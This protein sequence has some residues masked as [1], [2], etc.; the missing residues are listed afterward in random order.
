MYLPR[1]PREVLVAARSVAGGVFALG[2]GMATMMV[3]ACDPEAKETEDEVE[4]PRR[5]ECPAW[6]CTEKIVIQAEDMDE[7]AD[8]YG[9]DET[10]GWLKNQSLWGM[11][12]YPTPPFGLVAAGVLGQC[13]PTQSVDCEYI[14]YLEFFDGEQEECPCEVGVFGELAPYECCYNEGEEE[15]FADVVDEEFNYS[16]AEEIQIFIDCEGIDVGSRVDCF[17]DDNPLNPYYNELENGILSEIVI[18]CATEETLSNVTGAEYL[19][20]VDPAWSFVTVHVGSDEDTVPLAGMGATG[21]GT[22]EFLMGI[23]D[24]TDTLELEDD[25]SNWQFWFDTTIYTSGT[26]SAFTVPADYDIM[27]AGQVETD[28]YNVTFEPTEHASGA[29]NASTG[30]W[31]VDFSGE[32]TGGWAEIHLEG[33][34]NGFSP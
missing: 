1:T 24:A 6:I 25:Y 29:F 33:D 12:G 5:I 16:T 2:L 23:V 13:D 3:A 8:C 19:L 32:F 10:D 28:W 9:W 4:K 30:R 7:L 15:G 31:Y 27:G 22:E 26:P 17:L 21:S 11:E 14:V 20:E 34:Y 18:G